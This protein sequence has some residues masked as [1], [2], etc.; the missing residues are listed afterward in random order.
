M[1]FQKQLL[2]RLAGATAFSRLAALVIG[3]VVG[4]IEMSKQRPTAW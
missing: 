3:G 4:Q 1:F 2:L